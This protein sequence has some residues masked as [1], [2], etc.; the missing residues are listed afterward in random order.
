[1]ALAANGAITR[2]SSIF[3]KTYDSTGV[4]NGER[5]GLSWGQNGGWADG[6]PNAFPDWVEV[7][8]YGTKTLDE[9]DVFTVQDSYTSPSTP[10][11]TMTFAHYGI[12]NFEVQY[13]TGS[14]WLLVPGGAVTG[15]NL[16]WRQFAVGTV[17]TSK[18]RVLVTDGG[19][20]PQPNYGD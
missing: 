15:N 18:I 10:T 3:D 1:M 16:V 5:S 12:R 14:A 8:F 17:T 4:V 7:E 11:P 20:I 13:W 6:T 2:A 19:G 9:I